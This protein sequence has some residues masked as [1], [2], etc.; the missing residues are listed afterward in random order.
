MDTMLIISCILIVIGFLF[1][2]YYSKDKISTSEGLFSIFSKANFIV[3]LSGGIAMGL[4]FSTAGPI[5]EFLLFGGMVLLVGLT[6]LSIIL[7][8]ISLLIMKKSKG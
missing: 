6:L 5:N 2:L 7:L 4:W 8:L 3:L 1:S